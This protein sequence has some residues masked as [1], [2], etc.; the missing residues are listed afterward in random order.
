M[1]E[2]LLVSL[3]VQYLQINQYVLH[4][5]DIYRPC[6]PYSKYMAANAIG[7]GLFPKPPPQ[8]N[9][10]QHTDCIFDRRTQISV[11]YG[12]FVCPF[13]NISS[14]TNL[15]HNLVEGKSRESHSLRASSVPS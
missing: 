10:Y 3:I 7:I 8:S 11:D 5:E 9:Y 6:L 1:D 13:D 2:A 4:S 12:N 15:V 14:A